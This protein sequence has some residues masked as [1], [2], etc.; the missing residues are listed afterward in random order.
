MDDLRELVDLPD[1]SVQPRV[2]P[3]DLP[4]ARESFRTGWAISVL[5]GPAVGVALAAVAW[6]LSSSYLVAAVAGLSLILLGAVASRDRL[7]EAWE[8]IP[9]KRQ[10]R[11]RRLPIAWDLVEGITIGGSVALTVVIVADRLAEPDIEPG[12]RQFVVGAGIATKCWSS[13]TCSE[14][15]LC[16]AGRRSS[17]RG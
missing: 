9:R 6:S 12:V 16:T 14:A 5:A 4:E 15:C 10:D 2:H 11:R 17:G 3:L 13:S 1:P 7:S 8:Y